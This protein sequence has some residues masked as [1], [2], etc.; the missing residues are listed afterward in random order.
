MLYGT[1]FGAIKYLDEANVDV[2]IITAGR[3]LL[4]AIALFPFLWRQNK[5]LFVKG[6][7]VRKGTSGG[8]VFLFV[9]ESSICVWLD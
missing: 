8:V 4:A 9:A 7:E 3:F 1:N 2:S 5:E 6:F